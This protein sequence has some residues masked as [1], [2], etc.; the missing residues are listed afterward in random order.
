MASWWLMA[1]G[2]WIG[3]LKASNRVG[4]CRRWPWVLTHGSS[5][6]SRRCVAERRLKLRSERLCIDR[7]ANPLILFWVL[8]QQSLKTE[9]AEKWWHKDSS[10]VRRLVVRGTVGFAEGQTSGDEDVPTPGGSRRAR[11][12]N[13]RVERAV[14]NRCKVMQT[15]A[16][17]CNRV[18][19]AV[20]S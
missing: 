16:N 4:I 15:S 10:M 20:E 8:L 18:P 9:K 3:R 5:F 19:G 13:W 11:F 1:I 7:R 2:R 14:G 6:Q 12:G 17:Q